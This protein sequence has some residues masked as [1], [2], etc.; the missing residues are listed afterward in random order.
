MKQLLVMMLFLTTAYSCSNSQEVTSSE[1]L[2]H[3]GEIAFDAILDDPEF[4]E[5]DTLILFLKPGYKGEK[6]AIVSHFQEKFKSDGFENASGYITI[7]F[8]INDEGKAGRF[9]IKS[10]GFNYKPKEFD[11]K[12]TDQILQ[13]TKELKAWRILEYNGKRYD[14]YTHL[15][16]KLV[17]GEIKQILL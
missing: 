2:N 17:N 1:Y 5:S 15:S 11:K 4:K 8:L 14:Y 12:L 13:L 16:F 6:P 3:V 7:G 9:R 10:M